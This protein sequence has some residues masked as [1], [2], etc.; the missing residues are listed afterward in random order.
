MLPYHGSCFDGKTAKGEATT[1]INDC[2][3]G[4]RAWKCGDRGRDA[5]A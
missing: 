5:T 2:R 1:W 4:D 3:E